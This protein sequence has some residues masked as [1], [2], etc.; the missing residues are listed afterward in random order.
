MAPIN[1]KIDLS[2][3]LP[4]LDE[5]KAIETCLNQILQTIHKHHLS[6]EIIIVDN[7]SKDGSVSIIQKIIRENASG[8]N[9]EIPIQLVKESVL[10]YGS[11]YQKVSR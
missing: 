1:K 7:G 11:A 5:E 6:A 10:G 8:K 2:I 9:Q 4:C 3:V